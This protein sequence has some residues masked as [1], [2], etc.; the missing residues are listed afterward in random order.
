MNREAYGD[1]PTGDPRALAR[2][3]K[4]GGDRLIL[5]MAA[6]FMTEVPARMQAAARA[7]SRGER[8]EAQR[9]AHSLKSSCAQLGA[10]RMRAIC[11]QLESVAGQE[12]P[13]S[14]V[15]LIHMLEDEFASFTAWLDH[16][17]MELRLTHD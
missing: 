6:L 15:S 17:T 12:N 3:R 9:A 7:A 1:V 13:Q 8:I 2:L 10:A 16:T 11:E 5:E 4:W 14:I